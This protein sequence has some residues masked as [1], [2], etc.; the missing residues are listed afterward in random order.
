MHAQP[1]AQLVV[2]IPMADLRSGTTGRGLSIGRASTEVLDPE[3]VRKIGCDAEIVLL[4]LGTQSEPLAVGRSKRLVTPGLLKALWI[5]DKGCTFPGCHAPPAWSDAHHIRHWA[6][7][8]PTDLANLALLC[9]RHHTTVHRT[10]ASAQVSD[11]AVH[12][13][14]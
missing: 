13:R 8:G 11:G 3:T 9:Q 5:R 1:K 7:G 4:A 14:L 12:W 10:G 2:T 6:D